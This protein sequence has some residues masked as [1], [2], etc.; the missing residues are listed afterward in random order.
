M[1][2]FTSLLL[3]LN[4]LTATA[5]LSHPQ[6]LP[7]RPRGIGELPTPSSVVPFPTTVLSLRA[8]SQIAPLIPFSRIPL[9]L[10]SLAVLQGPQDTSLATPLNVEIRAESPT[11]AC[12]AS[13]SCQQIFG[14]LSSC[15]SITK[16]EPQHAD[17]LVENIKYRTC[18]CEALPGWKGYVEPHPP[19][20]LLMRSY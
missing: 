8:G 12:W 1:S 7:S 6:M 9:Y 18:L 3:V 13:T 16:L 14:D 5:Q 10:P 19:T 17:D 15:L 20:A 2:R 11:D 4:C